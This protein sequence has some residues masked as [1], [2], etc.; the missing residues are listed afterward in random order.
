MNP[1]VRALVKESQG[2][3][4]KIDD[5]VTHCWSKLRRKKVLFEEVV[6]ELALMGLRE[7]VY[8]IRHENLTKLKFPA[9]ST[10]RGPEAI[11]SLA[12]V[13][14]ASLLNSWTMPDG[15]VLGDV[16]GSELPAFSTTEFQT[17]HGHRLS[18]RFYQSLSNKVGSDDRVRDSLN[19]GEVRSIW[20]TIL[21]TTGLSEQVG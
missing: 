12:N 16:L 10:T 5:V 13:A 20:N 1:E 7:T 2:K 18:A 21:G 17:A 6:S 9:T 8:D 14:A 19:D 4:D 15:R 11:A 3:F